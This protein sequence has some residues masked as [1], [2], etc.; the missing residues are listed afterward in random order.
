VNELARH[1]LCLQCCNDNPDL[2]INT[3]LIAMSELPHIRSLEAET[4]IYLVLAQMI[5]WYFNLSFAATSLP[6]NVPYKTCRW[7]FGICMLFRTRY[8]TDQRHTELE[9]DGNIFKDGVLLS[10]RELACGALGP[11]NNLHKFWT[12]DFARTGAYCHHNNSDEATSVDRSF[13]KGIENTKEET[14]RITLLESLASDRCLIPYVLFCWIFANLLDHDTLSRP[15]ACLVFITFLITVL[16][17]DYCRGNGGR[18][19]FPYIRPSRKGRSTLPGPCQSCSSFSRRAAEKTFICLRRQYGDFESLPIRK[20]DLNAVAIPHWSSEDL[21][22]LLLRGLLAL[23]VLLLK[24]PELPTPSHVI[25]QYFGQLMLN[26]FSPVTFWGSF[27]RTIIL[28]SS[29]IWITG[30][31]DWI[32]FPLVDSPA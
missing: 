7:I 24:D 14:H 29:W 9:E 19:L 28:I 6:G 30:L 15:T 17:W 22:Y 11:D 18:H 16:T 1:I 10:F 3:E 26:L 27:V 23:V 5:D 31:V 20:L 13:V 32:L 8:V 2:S 25:V 4:L 12:R 21:N